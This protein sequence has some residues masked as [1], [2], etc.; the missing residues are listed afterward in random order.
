[1][2]SRNTAHTGSVR[3]IEFNMVRYGWVRRDKVRLGLVWD[4]VKIFYG[5]ARLGVARSGTV[6][7][8]TVR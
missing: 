5:V 7:Q 6:G 2:I 4:Y 3:R 1:M 8:G